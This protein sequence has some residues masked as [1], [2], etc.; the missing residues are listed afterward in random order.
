M[1]S[2]S[3]LSTH[4]CFRAPARCLIAD[5]FAAEFVIFGKLSSWKDY[6]A[7]PCSAIQSERE[8]IMDI[9][10]EWLSWRVP[11]TLLAAPK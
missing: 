9:K 5:P 7:I 11:G 3:W 1:A 6:C 10:H 2:R 8:T 4:S